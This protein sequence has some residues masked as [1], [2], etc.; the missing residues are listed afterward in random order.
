MPPIPRIAPG[1]ASL[2]PTSGSTKGESDSGG[3]GRG[4]I[5]VLRHER[6][7]RVDDPGEGHE[8]ES[9]REEVRRDVRVLGASVVA[10]RV[11]LPL[12]MASF[13]WFTL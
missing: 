11:V 4:R 2:R 5:H 9:R 3:S 1:P 13:I 6:R 10:D 7:L 8:R 12:W